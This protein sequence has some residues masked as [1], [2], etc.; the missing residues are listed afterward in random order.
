MFDK[1][2]KNAWAMDR[3]ACELLDNKDRTNTDITEAFA[4][5]NKAANQNLSKA[6][7]H[8]EYYKKHSIHQ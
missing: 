8:L 6:I 7:R 1:P 2:T 4:L 5:L 3:L